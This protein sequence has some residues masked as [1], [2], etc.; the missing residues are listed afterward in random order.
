MQTEHK[1]RRRP[2]NNKLSCRFFSFPQENNKTMGDIFMSKEARE[3][4][5]GKHVA[6]IGGSNMRGLYK[7]IVW[8]LNDDSFI[9]VEV[10]GEKC[11]MNFP[12]F[13]SKRWI[14]KVTQVKKEPSKRLRKKFENNQDFL[15]KNSSLHSGREYEEPRFYTYEKKAI[16]INYLF[17]TRV[18]SPALDKWLRG[19]EEAQQ[20]KLDLIIMNSVL[21]DVNRWGP[22]GIDDFKKNLAKLLTCVK[23]VLAE[24]GIFIW[25]TAQPGSPELHSKAMETPGLEFQKKTTR[26][27][28]IEANFYA[29]H[30][31]AEAGFDVIDLHYYFLLQTFRRNNDGI[32]W[33]PEANRF[34]SNLILTHV[35]L[36]DGKTLP[37]RNSDDYALLRTKYISDIGQGK[38]SLDKD[39]EDRLAQLQRVAEVMVKKGRKGEVQLPPLQVLLNQGR[40]NGQ[41]NNVLQTRQEIRSEQRNFNA[42]PYGRG[43]RPQE[44]FR[45]R[46]EVQIWN[47]GNLNPMQGHFNQSQFQGNPMEENFFQPQQPQFQGNPMLKGNF[48]HS[49]FQ[50]N[51]YFQQTQFHE[52]GNFHP[53]QFQRNG[54]NFQQSQFH[55]DGNFQ[56]PHFQ[57]NQY[58]VNFQQ[59]QFQV[60]QNF[61]LN[62]QLSDF[63]NDYS[64]MQHQNLPFDN[65]PR[66]H[67]DNGYNQNHFENM[68]SFQNE[69]GNR[70]K[71]FGGGAKFP[72]KRQRK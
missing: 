33:T 15:C 65:G 39:H 42:C 29:A 45:P 61:N 44:N 19:R 7:D 27:N 6:V 18:W 48:Q 69:R 60:P 38:L 25:M 12:D 52:R 10:L 46:P 62:S 16:L 35:A 40:G 23:S 71:R 9:P 30:K 4:L 34:A 22:N 67:C 36:S 56:P 14:N 13:N 1:S 26:Y 55:G 31:V 63:T 5:K 43:Q 8:L 21:W 24:D 17:V 32:H 49:Q 2:D 54:V 47:G 51:G 70:R 50:G 28:I 41:S 66:F 20:C 11:E 53:S 68:Q 64:L 59:P 58:E 3:A 57:E 37:G 72:K